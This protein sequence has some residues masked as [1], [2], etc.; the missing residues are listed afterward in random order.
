MKKKPKEAYGISEDGLSV[1][2]VHLIKDGS[3]IYLQA[4]ER[5]ELDAP[6]YHAANGTQILDENGWD[7]PPE[8]E[9]I[10]VDDFDSE[11]ITAFKLQPFD[12]MLSSYNIS[13]GVLAIN[14][15]DDNLQVLPDQK[16]QGREI[17]K[18][19]KNLIP[20]DIYKAGEWQYSIVPVQDQKEVWLHSGNNKL[21]D[22]IRDY[23]KKTKILPF[24]QLADANDLALTDFFK[25]CCEDPSGTR[26]LVYIGHEYRKAF[27]F[28]DGVMTGVFPLQISQKTPESDIIYSKL[29][30]VLDNA[31]VS[32]PNSIVICGDFATTD[33]LEYLRTQFTHSRVEFL[34]YNNISVNR[35]L[36]DMFDLRYLVQFAL[37]IAL[38]YKAL[39]PDKPGFVPSNFLPSAIIEGQK[40]FKIAWHGFVILFFIF[41]M[42]LYGTVQILQANLNLKQSKEQGQR[43]EED[44]NQKRLEAA[45][46]KKIRSDIELHEENIEAM[47]SILD[48]KNPWTEVLR[49]LIQELNRRPQSWL[50]NLR[51]DS[52]R[53]SLS[54][55]TTNRQHVVGISELFENCIISKVTHTTVRDKSLWQFEMTCDLPSINWFGLIEADLERLIKVKEAYGEKAVTPKDSVSTAKVE[56][57]TPV[58]TIKPVPK[59]RVREERKVSDLAFGAIPDKYLPTPTAEEI[60]GLEPE[61]SFD[62]KQFMDSIKKG[63]T[64]H[65]RDL[66][67][68]YIK[69]HSQSDMISYVR[70]HMAHRYYIDK[71]YLHAMRTLDPMLRNQNRFY[72]YSLLLAARIEIAQGNIRYREFY[73]ILIGDYGTHIVSAQVREDLDRLKRER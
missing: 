31:Q 42:T 9:E 53:L 60:E 22:M 43:L 32:D 39:N 4:V 61:E 38:A 70:W 17:K 51:L 15:Y 71:E 72:P 59:E 64:W 67:F 56:P 57:G 41:A 13:K 69:N 1:K 58:S 37:P 40:V 21:L 16:P 7:T 29:S 36:E 48:G 33:T 11:A 34:K 30:L 12:S 24:Y 20:K 6:L 46:I 35:E 28:H 8:P 25:V 14:V 55:V 3:E 10:T 65:Y 5:I 68:R 62:F 63:S 49:M 47:R 23:Q 50:T 2:L 27:L 54:G 52:G 45:E 73:N 19:V 66:G 18:T 26:V 44:V